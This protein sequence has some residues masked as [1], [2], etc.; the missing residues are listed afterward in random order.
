MYSVLGGHTQTSVVV[1]VAKIP[2]ITVFYKYL[3][4]NCFVIFVT[5]EI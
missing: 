5:E 1:V 3:L 4:L 2:S